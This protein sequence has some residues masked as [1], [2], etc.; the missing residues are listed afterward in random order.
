MTTGKAQDNSGYTLEAQ[1]A[2]DHTV[3][4]ALAELYHAD[5]HVP[6]DHA[7]TWANCKTCFD[8]ARLLDAWVERDRDL[9]RATL[10]DH[11]ETMAASWGNYADRPSALRA[12]AAVVRGNPR[13]GGGA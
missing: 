4:N 8:L 1:S 5:T 3:R 13:T 11:L 2:D 9:L 12:A 10:A 7:L 6:Y